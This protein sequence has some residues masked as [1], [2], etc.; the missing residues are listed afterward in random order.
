MLHSR[1]EFSLAVRIH[2]STA[3]QI[4][5]MHRQIVRVVAVTLF[6]ITALIVQWIVSECAMTQGS[7]SFLVWFHR[8]RYSLA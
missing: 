2:H 8:V 4:A 7:D 3:L 1:E 6:P 5:H